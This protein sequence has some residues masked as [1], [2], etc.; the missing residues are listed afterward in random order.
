MKNTWSRL[1][2]PLFL[3]TSACATTA[4]ATSVPGAS[5]PERPFGT[6][7]EQATRQQAWLSER[8]EKALPALMRQY[9][10]EMWVI[11]MREYNEDP[12]F[13]ALVAPT[14]F[15]ARRRTIYVFHDRGPE[16]GVERLALGGGT[17]GGVYEARRAQLQVDGG[18]VTRQAELW[19]P[20]QWKVLK[21]VLEERKPKVIG[22]NVSRT[23]AFADGLTHGEYEGMAE[24]L[25]T[26]WT[27]RMKPAEGLAVDLIAWRGED[28]ARFYEDLTKL[29][30]NII[31]T[32][33][34]NQVITPGKTRT[35][36]V[37]WW[38]RQRVNDLGLGTWF[39]PSVSVQRQGKTEEEL[40]QD[41]LIERGDVLHC[42][43][44]VTALR[45]NTDTQHMGYVLREGETD[46][47]AGL[48][49]ALARSNRLQDIVF[50]ELR[51]GRTGNEILKASRERM[52]S[53]GIDGTVYS[54]PIGLNGH[55][56]G[57][58]IGLWDR[59]EGVPGNGDHKVIPNQWFSIELQATS[60]VPEWGGQRVRSAQEEDV[61][62]DATGKVRWALQ[63]Q[64]AFHLVR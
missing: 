13:P 8:M 30:W 20:D 21:A 10:I 36:D 38:M 34:S 55:G 63:R 43:F 61:M 6:L 62:I 46:V 41:P 23:F 60:P 1:L 14:T 56:A 32:G 35:S 51:P 31:E 40:G 58:M 19:G 16:L 52:K 27:S 57:P 53:E 48:K 22:I 12:V 37:V 11:S 18:G 28:E 54:H 33:F 5:A 64:T 24:A 44:G 15:A 59:Q 42:D 47:P 3:F 2:V 49:A 9:G 7:R 26:E 45:L 25:G 39:Q 4:P 50:E 17:Q 29:A